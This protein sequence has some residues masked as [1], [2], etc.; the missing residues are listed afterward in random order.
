M[1]KMHGFSRCVTSKKQVDKGC[2]N[3]SNKQVN[4]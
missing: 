2:D 4:I 3:K 1:L